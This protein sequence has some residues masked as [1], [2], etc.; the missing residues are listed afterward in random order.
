MIFHTNCSE[1]VAGFSRSMT[2]ICVNGCLEGTVSEKKNCG[3]TFLPSQQVPE[4]W[5]DQRGDIRHQHIYRHT[6]QPL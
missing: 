6:L 3:A 4:L 2:K 5:G 1:I